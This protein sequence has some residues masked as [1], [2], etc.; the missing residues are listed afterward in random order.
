VPGSDGAR[1]RA[2]GVLAAAHAERPA[3]PSRARRRRRVAALA[4]AAVAAGA[5]VALA[6]I[7]LYA[8]AALLRP[9]P[10]RTRGARRSPVEALGG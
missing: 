6:A 4:F 9:A 1:E 7:A 8:L 10:A 5:A 2:R 3:A